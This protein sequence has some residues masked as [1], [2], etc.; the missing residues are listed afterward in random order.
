MQIQLSYENC[1]QL[2]HFIRLMKRRVKSKTA[3]YSQRVVP[4]DPGALKENN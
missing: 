1:Y 4:V 2:K 3:G